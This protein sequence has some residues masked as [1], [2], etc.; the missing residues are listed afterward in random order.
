[1]M[2]K[3][4]RPWPPLYP[5]RPIQAVGGAGPPCP[6]TMLPHR[7]ASAAAV[8][9]CLHHLTHCRDLY[10]GLYRAAMPP[11]A[12]CPCAS[13]APSHHRLRSRSLDP[14]PPPSASDSET[15][16]TRRPSPPSSRSRPARRHYYQ[17]MRRS[18]EDLLDS[19]KFFP[20]RSSPVSIRQPFF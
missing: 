2:L 3:S 13:A 5:C 6:V 20:S 9:H 17:H 1:M 7:A 18:T 14:A 12:R 10:L 16:L 4:R 8:Q 19:S 11:P 15:D